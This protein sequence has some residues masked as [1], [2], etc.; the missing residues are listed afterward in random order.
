MKKRIIP[1]VLIDS[2]GKVVISKQFNPW[3][4][5]GMLMQSL[6]MNEQREAD[7]LLILD[8][9]AS[10]EGRAINHRILKII[11]DNVRIPITVGGGIHTLATAKNY[12]NRGADKVCLNSAVIDD[13]EIVGKL[14]MSLGSQAVVVNI[15]Y[16][17]VEGQPR[18]YDH[19]FKSTLQLEFSE[20][21]ME[22]MRQ[23]PGEI[24]FTSVDKDGSL[25]GF[26]HAI[27]EYLNKQNI[28]VPV[29]I[30]GGGGNP[31]D[32]IRMLNENVSAATGA[33]IFFLTEHTPETLR[34][35]CQLEGISM[36][37]V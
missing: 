22:V 19:R 25:N 12:I 29:I 15:N 34:E 14:S 18:I 3:R 36:R 4:T 2:G 1:V 16:Q 5:V 7:E 20:F 26:D 9:L 13:V 21:I 28:S 30:S 37:A 11:S 24:I 23:G 31:P 32:F 10:K 35:A 6:R 8:I 17:W 27:I 33:S